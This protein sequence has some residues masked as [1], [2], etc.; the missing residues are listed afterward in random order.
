[1]ALGGIYLPSR[2][3]VIDALSSNPAGLPVV[4]DRTLDLS[5][6]SVF[7]RGSFSNSVNTNVPL[8]DG[9]GVVP[10][11]GFGMPIAHS[12][13]SIGLGLVPEMLSVCNWN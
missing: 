6:T 7:A 13:F 11:G 4:G 1:M 5:L 10:Y 8:N 12:R 2:G 3:G 9:P